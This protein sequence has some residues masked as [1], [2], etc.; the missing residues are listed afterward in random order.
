[1]KKQINR[2]TIA[3]IEKIESRKIIDGNYLKLL[4]EEIDKYNSNTNNPYFIGDVDILRQEGLV[5]FKKFKK[6]TNPSTLELIDSGTTF[7]NSDYDLKNAYK[8]DKKNNHPFIIV[9]RVNKKIRSLPIVYKSNKKFLNRNYVK[10]AFVENAKDI[11]FV[12]LILDNEQIKASVR[13]SVN[14]FDNLYVLRESLKYNDPERVNV[15]A[16]S[17]FYKSF[18]TEGGNFNYFNF[19]LLGILLMRYEKSL[20]N[21]EEEEE[22][23]MIMEEIADDILR[24][25]YDEL[26]M[27]VSEEY[28]NRVLEKRLVNKHKTT[29]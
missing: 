11:S 7:L 29:K 19:R 21:V 2:Y 9:Y 10:V 6:I 5:K 25:T 4:F 15:K 27:R 26:K 1:M 3:Q 22:T 28:R 13:N 18:I 14:D 24:D 16:M 17:E 23:Q 8:T 12:S 20:V